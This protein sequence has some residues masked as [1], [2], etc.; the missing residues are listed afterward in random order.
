MVKAC[1]LS[2]EEFTEL[3][4]S[5]KEFEASEE[6][7]GLNTPLEVITLSTVTLILAERGAVS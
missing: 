1:K 5:S 3:D 6:T 7:T 2:G 4:L